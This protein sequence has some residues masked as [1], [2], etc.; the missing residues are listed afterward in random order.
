MFTLNNKISKILYIFLSLVLIL[1]FISIIY[2]TPDKIVDFVGDENVF[3]ILFVSAFIGGT[4]ILIPFPHYL[5]TIS[6][7]A[8]GINPLLLG[9]SAASGTILGDS[10]SYLMG[11]LGS[12][13]FIKEK[14]REKFFTK[15][16]SYLNNKHPVVL[17]VALFVYASIAPLPD[18]LIMIPAGIINYPYRK[19]VIPI[20]LGKI[21]FNTVL[22][23]GG[24]YGWNLITN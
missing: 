21:I 6:F 23:L 22:A 3:I 20:F 1:F 8:A 17:P 11:K 18:D 14:K 19:L 13:I 5:F 7:G 9:L 10:I 12:K 4:S 2:L 24:Y 15:I 16:L